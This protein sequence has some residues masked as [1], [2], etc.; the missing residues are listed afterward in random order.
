MI[1]RTPEEREFYD[2]RLKLVRDEEARLLFARIEGR[3][4][5]R[6]EGREEGRQ[7]GI[8]KGL[9]AGKI[10]LLQQLLGNTESQMSDLE[11]S[12]VPELC[13]LLE[14]LQAQLRSRD[15]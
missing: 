3:E 11:N 8:E 4:E 15:N 1:A 13:E 12:T 6:Q 5:G 10:Q 7:E 14:S 2:S 9:L